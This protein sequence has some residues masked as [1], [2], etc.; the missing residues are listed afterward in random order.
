MEIKLFFSLFRALQDLHVKVKFVKDWRVKNEARV[1]A[2]HLTVSISVEIR[3]WQAHVSVRV[4][5]PKEGE[6]KLA[7]FDIGWKGPFI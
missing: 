6:Y 4:C 1:K 5:T 7:L 3:I 2:A